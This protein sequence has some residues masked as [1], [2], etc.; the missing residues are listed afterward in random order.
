MDGQL[1]MKLFQI[2]WPMGVSVE[3]LLESG[4]HKVPGNLLEKYLT[5]MD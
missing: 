1:W 4:V 2:R 3:K 5:S